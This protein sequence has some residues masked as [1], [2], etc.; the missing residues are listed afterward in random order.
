[1]VFSWWQKFQKLKTNRFFKKLGN[2]KKS[3]TVRN[4]VALVT[5]AGI[6]LSQARLMTVN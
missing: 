6:T 3:N 2:S 5:S 4:K 1:M